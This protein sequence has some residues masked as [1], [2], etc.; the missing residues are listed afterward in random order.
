MRYLIGFMWVLLLVGSDCNDPDKVNSGGDCGTNVGLKQCSTIVIDR[1]LVCSADG[2]W[3][4][5]EECSP[6]YCRRIEGQA[7]CVECPF[8][9][10]SSRCVDEY[11]IAENCN[12]DGAWESETCV[13]GTECTLL[14]GD[15]AICVSIS[16]SE[17]DTRC[18]DSGTKV[19]TCQGGDWVTVTC[20]QEQECREVDNIAQCVDVP[21][22]EG[23]TRC[24]DNE[25]ET[26]Q[27]GDWNVTATCDQDQLCNDLGE[28]AQCVDAACTEGETGCADNEVETCNA[29]G[30]WTVT[31]TCVQGCEVVNDEARCTVDET[32]CTAN[33]LFDQRCDPFN[34]IWIQECRNTGTEQ[35]PVYEWVDSQNCSLQ[36]P[37]YICIQEM[38]TFPYCFL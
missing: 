19:Q 21:C 23:E 9:E 27:G 28:T 26:C 10:I 30:L 34:E 8:P 15:D 38:G 33:N 14:Q 7:R 17:G 29:L 36:S 24:A 22:T 18:V 16:C 4:V 32:Q 6:Y 5:D 37:D 31:E 1:L 20:E 35:A 11:R 12:A 3:V 25:V 2:T 13:V